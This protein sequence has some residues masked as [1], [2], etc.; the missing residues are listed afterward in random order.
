M[1]APTEILAEQHYNNLKNLFEPWDMKVALV[2]GGQKAGE[3]GENMRMIEDGEA[4]IIV[5]THAV[6]G[7]NV[8]IENVALTITDEQ[9]RFGVKQRSMLAGKGR[10][11]HNL[12]MTATPIP[13]TLSLVIYGDLDVSCDRR[14]PA[15]QK[16]GKDLRYAGRDER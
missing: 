8:N 15:R 4:D 6:I 13:R 9:H 14:A 1:M 10:R 7:E 11:S 16:A 12:V 2:T 3:R 5:G